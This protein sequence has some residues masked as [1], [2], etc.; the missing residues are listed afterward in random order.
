MAMMKDPFDVP[1]AATQACS[2]CTIAVGDTCSFLLTRHEN[3]KHDVLNA[4]C[5]VCA[6]VIMNVRI[7]ISV[8][9]TCCGNLM[10][11]CVAKHTIVLSK[12]QDGFL[13]Q[14]APINTMDCSHTIHG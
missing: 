5:H 10:S 1:L 9:A 2:G 11:Q 4:G 3:A 13:Q 8:V 14:L 6:G 7:A 12:A